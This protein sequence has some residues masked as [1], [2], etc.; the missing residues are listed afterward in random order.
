[1]VPV[2]NRIS[3]KV[4]LPPVEVLAPICT[5]SAWVV[6]FCAVFMANAVVN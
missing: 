1:M 3:S 4:K 2:S 5:E 6:N